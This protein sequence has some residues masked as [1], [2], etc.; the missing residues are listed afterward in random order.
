MEELSCHVNEFG[1]SPQALE[2]QCKILSTMV[3]GPDLHF[4]KMLSVDVS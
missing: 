3:A 2:G 1:L 4:G